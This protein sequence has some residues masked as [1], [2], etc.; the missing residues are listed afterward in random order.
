MPRT[1]RNRPIIESLAVFE[2]PPKK[3]GDYMN[4]L[5]D[6]FWGS[7]CVKYILFFGQMFFRSETQ[8]I[9]HWLFLLSQ[10]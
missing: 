3:V 6:M 9:L 8:T 1:S 5:Y 4:S 7:D 2:A 10:N